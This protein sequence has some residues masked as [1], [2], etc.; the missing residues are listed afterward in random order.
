MVI[1]IEVGVRRMKKYFVELVRMSWSALSSLPYKT[2]MQH[3]PPQTPCFRAFL[4]LEEIITRR[5][6]DFMKPLK[7]QYFQGFSYDC[8]FK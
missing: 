5:I 8:V 3:H 1:N 4:V 6:R 7:I 2:H